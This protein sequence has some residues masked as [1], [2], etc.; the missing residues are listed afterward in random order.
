MEHQRLAVH[1]TILVVDVEGFGDQRRTNPHR[2]AVREGM[3]QVL[4]RSFGNSGVRWADCYQESCGDGVFVLIPAEVPKSIFIESLPRELAE[5][6]REHNAAHRAEEQIRLRMALHA[7]EVYYDEHGVTAASI[8]LAFRLLDAAP[9]KSALAESPGTLALIVSSWF[10]DEVVRHSPAGDAATYRSIRVSVKETTTVAWIC[11]PDHPYPP[12]P[13]SAPL[14]VFLSHTSELREHP[15][16]RSFVTAAEQAVIRAGETVMNMTYF[17]GREDRPAAYCRRQVHSANVYVGVI[18]FRYGSPVKDQPGLSYSELEFAAAT[19][20]GLPRLVFLLDEDAVLPLP[21]KYLSDPRYDEQQRGFRTRAAEAGAAVQRVGSP[22]QLEL[23]VFQALKELRQQTEQR[24]ESG[25]QRQRQPEL[26]PAMRRARFVNPPPMTAPSWFQDRYVETRLI[27][28]FLRDDG[29]RLLTVVGRGGVGKT[30]MVC[31]LLKALEAGQLPDDGGELSADA[32]VYLSPVGIHPV[33]FQ[34]LFADLTRLLPDAAAERLLQLYREPLQPGRLMLT[35]LEAFPGGRSVVLL[36]NLEEVIDPATLALSD[37]ELGAAL[38]ELLAA[39]QHGIKVIATT[40]LVPRDLLLRHPGRQQRLDLDAGLPAAEAIKVLHSMDPAGTLG[41]RDASPDLLAAICERTRGFPRALEAMTAILAADRDTSLPGLLAAA[42]NVLPGQIVEVLVGEAF[43]RL[44]PLGRQVM[45]ALA[46]YAVPVPPVAVDYLL[47]PI[48]PA[49]D[50]RPVL[51]RL[52]N[53]HF[54]RGDGGRYYLHQVDRDYAINSIPPGRPEDQGADPVP[55]T[56]HA[57]QARAADYFERTR[58]PRD[59]WRSLDDLG[60]QVAEFELRCAAADHDTA[61]AVLAGVDDY[62]QR[63]GHY[64]LA[65]Y[66]HERLSGRLNRPYG[67]MA[68]AN[69]LGT[70]YAALGQTGRAIEHYQQALAIARETGDRGIEGSALGNLGNSY[71]TLGQTGRAIEH[72]QQALAIARETGDRGIEGSALGSL[73]NGYADL[74]QTG[75]AIEYYEQALAIARETGHRS[76]EGLW[77]GGLGGC[78]ADLGQT[79]RAVEHYQQALAIAI[80]IGDRGIEGTALGNLGARY[81]DLGQTGRAVEYYEQALAIARETGDRAS[82]GSWLG[83]LGTCL[84]D[85]GQAGRAVEYY[86]QALAI[87]RE[88]GDRRS[89]GSW[90]GSLGSRHADLGQAGRAGEYYEQ[91][92]AIA[93]ETGDRASEGSWLGGLGTCFADLGQAGRAVEYYEQALAIA[94]ETGDRRSEGSWLGAIGN[95][96]ADLGQA[97]QAIEHYEEAAEIGADIANAQVQAEARLGLAYAHLD[98]EEWPEARRAAEAAR[99]HGYG[100]ALPQVFAAL[101]T[102]RLCGGDHANAHEAFSAALSAADSLLAGS[103]GMIY[104]LYVKGIARAG[105]AV[106]G[107]RG[108]ARAAR[109]AFEKALAAAPLPGVRMRILRQFDL[110][111]A[112][113]TGG[114]LAGIRPVLAMPS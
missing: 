44:D 14:R 103:N 25:L 16:D 82:E 94:R 93:R 46:V 85:L 35:L 17:T 49:I 108:A 112:A 99:S 98:R 1:R 87:A 2:L 29:L 53:M 111:A 20:Q 102:A 96:Y 43:E 41:L 91:A 110:L 47:Q 75:R 95:S 37:L 36:D 32:I 69:A 31:R 52:V 51:S 63:W 100:P 60:P 30:A 68:T 72:Y 73:G 77:L 9:L 6:L 18:G 19:E 97:E 71:S 56:V 114:V 81:A 64:R 58:T 105:Q 24:I 104:V 21:G 23:L 22:E 76:S 89:E 33:S 79:G 34:N 70:S 7:G 28:E 78:Y 42:E 88:T 11:R 80:E 67:Q 101:G 62:L 57:L 84:A 50:S 59:S 109:R 45:Q 65:V 10:F 13:G 66:M 113:D 15:Q 106:T 3:Y 74:G 83:G 48:E 55:F 39:P 8:N 107:E 38:G 5:A 26:K 86:E 12:G 61:A 40:R 90:L 27:G 92:L 4:Q 54:V